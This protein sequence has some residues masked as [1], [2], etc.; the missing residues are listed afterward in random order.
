LYT[1]H[2]FIRGRSVPLVYALLPGKSEA[3]YGEL[4][5]VLVQ[6]VSKHPKSITI[7][8]E[9]AVENVIKQKLPTTTI[10]GCFFHFKQALWRKIEDLG[11]QQPFVNDR[12]VRRYLK[13]FACLSFVSEAFVVEE[14]ERFQDESPDSINDLQVE[15]HANLIMAEKLEAGLVKLTKRAAYE[16]MDE[17]L[18]QLMTTFNINTRKEYFKRA[19]AFFNF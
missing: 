19:S 11:L 2:G 8:F 10:N 15:Q 1:I 13:N 12:E 18:E 7:D 17:Q 6:N 4:F 3:V 9:K 5:N 16:Q 14:F